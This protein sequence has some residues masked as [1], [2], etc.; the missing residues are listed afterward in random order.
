MD[1]VVKAGIITAVGVVAA[2]LI[3]VAVTGHWFSSASQTTSPPAGRT[4][5]AHSPPAGPATPAPAPSTGSTTPA[6]DDIWVAQLASVPISAGNARLQLVL[7]EVRNE[8]PGAKYLDSS[9]FSSLNPGYW[10]VYYNGSFHNG[11]Q[12]LAYCAAHG[13]VTRDQ[14]VGRLLSHTPADRIYI[15]FPPIGSNTSDCSHR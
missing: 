14:C 15:C 10:M 4:T 1:N 2:A 6:P 13:R 11:E 3:P 5:P 9:N 8:I 12:A 7:N